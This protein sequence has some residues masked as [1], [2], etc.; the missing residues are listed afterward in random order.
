MKNVFRVRFVWAC[1]TVLLSLG[2]TKLLYPLPTAAAAEIIN[3]TPGLTDLRNSA[4]AEAT[5]ERLVREFRKD[6]S[7]G[8]AIIACGLLVGFIL[9]RRSL[10]SH[11]LIGL[12]VFSMTFI[13]LLVANNFELFAAESIFVQLKERL[14]MVFTLIRVG[15][16]STKLSLA[17]DVLSVACT[18]GIFLFAV[19]NLINTNRGQSAPAQTGKW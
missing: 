6:A 8:F 19:A 15:R 17:H 7:V 10:K 12:S 9:F 11:H 3:A 16:L 2:F 4:F 5:R 13:V 14:D 1:L 18:L